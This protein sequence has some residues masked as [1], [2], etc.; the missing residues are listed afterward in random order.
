MDVVGHQSQLHLSLTQHL[1]REVKV[2]EGLGKQHVNVE[3]ARRG[4]VLD[5]PG[6][7]HRM[8]V[9]GGGRREGGGGRREEGGGGYEGTYVYSI[10]RFLLTAVSGSVPE[11]AV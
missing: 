3:L 4:E 6:T 5:G 11:R 7:H 8:L 2:Q 10:C 1:V 9:L